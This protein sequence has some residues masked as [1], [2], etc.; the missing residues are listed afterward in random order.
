MKFDNQTILLIVVAVSALAVLLQACILLA[1]LLAVRKLARTLQQDAADVRATAVEVRNAVLPI[2][3][4]SRELLNRVAPRVENIATDASELFYALRVQ[5]SDI[6]YSATEIL[7]RV[8]VQTSRIDT[9][10]TS[11]LDTTDRVS[12]FVADAVAKPV[13]QF[14][15]VLAGLRAVVETLRSPAQRAARSTV[16]TR[17]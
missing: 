14:S 11:A 16:E 13:R 10:L 4:T 12:A 15:G 3:E 6:H 7:E 8:R 2:L 5:A 9:M 17:R 1:I